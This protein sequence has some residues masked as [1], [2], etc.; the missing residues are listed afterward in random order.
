MRKPREDL[1]RYEA[2]SGKPD[3]PL[4]GMA[5]AT[6]PSRHSASP[7][8][9]MKLSQRKRAAAYA[10]IHRTIVDARI[11]LTLDAQRDATLAQVEH[12]LWSRLKTALDIPEIERKRDRD[13]WTARERAI[14][15]GDPS[16]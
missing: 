7:G 4:A 14:I 3:D 13:A 5:D 15:G 11:A 6:G 8:V 10:A 12:L 1:S 16:L 2:L 9:P